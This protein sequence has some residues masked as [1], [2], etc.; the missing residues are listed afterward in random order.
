MSRKFYAIGLIF[1]L[2]VDCIGLSGSAIAQSA[3]TQPM[4]ITEVQTGVIKGDGGELPAQEFVELT[5]TSGAGLDFADND[6]RLEYLSASND[7]THPPTKVLTSI[8]G[9]LGVDG[10]I[11][12]SH[13]GYM[14]AQADLFFGQDDADTT[15]YL[16]KTGGHV[17]LMEDDLMIDC[18]SW[19][20][21]TDIVGC[22]KISS[23]APAG[24]TIQRSPAEDGSYRQDLGVQNIAPSTPIGQD[25]YQLPESDLSSVTCPSLEISEILAN[26]AGDDTG[27]EYIEL[28]NLAD[29]LVPL[30]GCTLVVGNKA[31]GFGL[32]DSLAPDEY[33]PIYYAASNLQLPNN[34]G[35]VV[36]QGSLQAPII[37]PEAG[38]NQAWALINGSWQ[39]TNQP[40]PGA[41][42]SLAE[43]QDVTV[44]K[45]LAVAPTIEVKPKTCGAGKFLNP[46]TNRC[47]SLP[48]AMAP[49]NCA[50]N[51]QRN[52]ATGRC[53]AIVSPAATA[54]ACPAGQ[55]RNTSTNRCRKVIL[56]SKQSGASNSRGSPVPPANHLIL[57]GVAASLVLYGLYEYRNDIANIF[58]S[59]NPRAIEPLPDQMS[60]LQ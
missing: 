12:V 10:H 28:H 49:K 17:R 43:Q 51:Q 52:P 22:S 55:Q 50:A 59:G 32:G 1:M 11:L 53:K 44:K 25:S 45:E 15:S 8:T 9:K 6:W 23:L 18:V 47:K 4:L 33:R 27:G 34:G 58:R 41:A 26:P 13:T 40:T 16:A 21:A 5:N 7:G 46:A 42:N 30:Q 24:F 3:I 57:A 48:S 38:D 39:S 29:T 56:A 37:Y 36:L 35:L 54:K 14:S 19:G 2:L 31:F 60:L 20:S